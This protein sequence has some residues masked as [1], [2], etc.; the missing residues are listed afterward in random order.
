M[1]VQLFLIRNALCR[2]HAAQLCGFVK[3]ADQAFYLVIGIKILIALDPGSGKRNGIIDG[4]LQL[5]PV[6]GSKQEKQQ[7]SGHSQYQ[8]HSS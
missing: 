1:P 3:Q 4:A 5:S 7:D 2:D 8:E 6:H